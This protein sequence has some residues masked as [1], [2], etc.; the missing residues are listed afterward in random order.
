MTPDIKFVHL[1]IQI[2]KMVKGLTI[3]IGGGFTIAFYGIV[4]AL[5]ML[6]G[7]NLAFYYG[8]KDKAD[9]DAYSTF[10]LVVLVLSIIGARIYYVIF[11]WDSYKDDLLQIFNIRAGGLAIYGGVITAIITAIVFTRVKKMPF[12]E[13]A[14]HASF[15]LILGQAMGRWGNF[16]NC[17][18]FGGFTDGLFA[19]RIRKSLVSMDNISQSLADNIISVNGVEYIQ[20]HPTF[21]YES[22]WNVAGL[23]LMMCLRRFRKVDGENFCLYLAWYGIGRFWIESL[24]TDQLLLWNTKIPVSMIVSAVIAALGI[25]L[26]IYRRFVSK[27]TVLS[28]HVRMANAKQA[29]AVSGGTSKTIAAS[30]EKDGED[31]AEEMPVEEQETEEAPPAPTDKENSKP[32]WR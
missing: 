12:F 24:R 29:A 28:Y 19:M 13:L 7:M 1:G 32:S 6:A 11:A 27:T 31:D 23:V 26:W 4:I 16:F 20:V 17:E 5:G 8:R 10:A 25:G 22:M 2:E 3:P 30:E 21:L 15:G 9:V 14:D 18:A